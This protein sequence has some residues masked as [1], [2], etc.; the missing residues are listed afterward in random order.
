M[1]D[2][3][4]RRIMLSII[5]LDDVC[6]WMYTQAKKKKIV[7][8]SS[9]D[10]PYFIARLKKNLKRFSDRPMFVTVFFFKYYFFNKTTVITNSKRK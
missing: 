2:A 9:T 3:Q 6:L 1:F 5:I 4:F 10:R 7:Y 8:L